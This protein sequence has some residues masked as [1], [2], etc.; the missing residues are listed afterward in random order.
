MDTVLQISG[1][2]TGY[3]LFQNS[4]IKQNGKFN[5]KGQEWLSQD[6]GD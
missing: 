3:L 4:M 6:P 5:P 1:A 2:Q